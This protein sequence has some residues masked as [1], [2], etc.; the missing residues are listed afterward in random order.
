MGASDRREKRRNRVAGLTLVEVVISILVIAPLLLMGLSVFFRNVRSVT[1]EWSE[2]TSNAVGE[3]M[4][5]KIRGMN[6]DETTPFGGTTT[7]RSVILGADAETLSQYDDVDD[8]N[9]FVGADPVYLRYEVAV[10]V[11]YV[12]VVLVT[13]EMLPTG[14]PTDYKRVTVNVKGPGGGSKNVSSLFTNSFP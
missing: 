11:E 7:A 5:N 13:G 9:G 12:K 1:E 2:T 8:W 10:H 3:R 4:L 6:W 14:V